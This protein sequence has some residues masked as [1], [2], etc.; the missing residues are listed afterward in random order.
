MR[1][2]L[3]NESERRADWLLSL[4]NDRM[5]R[6]RHGNKPLCFPPQDGIEF[7]RVG[8]V[9]VR[10]IHACRF[11]GARRVAGVNLVNEAVAKVRT[12]GGEGRLVSRP[13]KEWG[14]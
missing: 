8:S 1:F 10:E 5:P 2:H 3:P 12:V 14:H 11:L 4:S 13:S 9:G 6:R 7:R